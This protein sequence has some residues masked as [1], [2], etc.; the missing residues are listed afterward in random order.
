MNG[1][2]V[3]RCYLTRV[4]IR[5]AMLAM[6]RKPPGIAGKSRS[7]KAPRAKADTIPAQSRTVSASKPKGRKD[8]P[9]HPSPE[10]V[11]QRGGSAV[12]QFRELVRQINKTS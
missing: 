4:P 6:D 2:S 5:A 12:E 8:S 9:D 7:H 1:C 10:E 11:K 3:R